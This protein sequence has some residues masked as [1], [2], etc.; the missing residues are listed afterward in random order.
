MRTAEQRCNAHCAGDLVGSGGRIVESHQEKKPH[1]SLQI[2]A[3]ARRS[4]RSS[5]F[6]IAT[7]K[8]VA[9]RL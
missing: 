3:S 8:L 4:T 2:D 5:A 9:V 6:A 1:C 7:L